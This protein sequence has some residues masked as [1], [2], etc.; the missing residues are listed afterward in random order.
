MYFP[1]SVIDPPVKLTILA[2]TRSAIVNANNVEMCSPISRAVRHAEPSGRNSAR[3]PCFV[4]HAGKH[5]ALLHGF[6]KF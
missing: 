3:L 1:L 6:R 5:V 2:F 4:H